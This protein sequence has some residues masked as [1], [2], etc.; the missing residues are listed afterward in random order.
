V[1][2]NVLLTDLGIALLAV[3][4]VLVVTPG[5]AIAGVLALVVL[6]VYVFTFVRNARRARPAR[7]RRPPR[8]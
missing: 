5:L 1:R 2:R 4:I 3:I 6:G 7:A 8:R